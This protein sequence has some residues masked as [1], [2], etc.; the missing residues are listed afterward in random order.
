MM[1]KPHIIA[2]PYPGQGHVIPTMELCLCLVKHGCKVTF[3]NSEFNHKRIMESMS[4]ADNAINLVSVPD[5]LASEEDRNDLKKLTEAFFEVVPGKLEALIHNI[6]ESDENRV[7][8]VIADENLGWALDLAKKLGLQRVAFWTA[9]AASLAMTFNV[10]KLVDDGIVG[11]NGEILKRQSIKLLPLMPAMNSTDLK[12]NCFSDPGLRRL[13]FD[14]AFKN[15]ES[16]KAAEWIICN[17]SQVMEC[18][19]FAFYPKLIPIGPLLANNR[20]GKTS[21]HFWREDTDCLKWLHQQPLNSVIYVAF[22]SLTI[23]NMAEF[24]ELAL[25]LELTNRPFLWVVRQGFIEEAG[26]PYPEGFIDRTRNRGQVVEWAPQQKVLAHPSL[27]CFLSHC[28]WNSTIEGVSNGLPFLCWPYSSDQ[29]FNKSYICDIW[30]IGLGFDRNENGIIGRLE[31]KN[32]V[33]QLFVDE[34]F[35]ARAVDLQAEVLSSVK[36]GGSSYRNFIS[37]VNWIKATN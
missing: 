18:D 29:L 5:G 2:I 21:G 26:N 14:L 32:K 22:G 20:L 25:G 3:V 23:F 36:G 1:R 8:C 9:S 27:G 13:V 12:W 7:S 19:V 33:E 31:I 34:N 30:K 11:N 28:G 17:S 15:N 4:E 35:K 37:F 16:V 10:S 24:H 6:N